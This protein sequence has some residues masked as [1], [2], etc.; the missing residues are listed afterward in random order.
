[1]SVK[2]SDNAKKFV[3]SGFMGLV[4]IGQA[5]ITFTPLF[6]NP[7]GGWY[8][9]LVDY[10]MYAFAKRE[11][12]HV[13]VRWIIEVETADGARREV[14]AEDMGLGF[15]RFMR[16]GMILVNNPNPNVVAHVTNAVGKDKK[17]VAIDV[18]K[19]PI[20]VTREGPKRVKPK[21]MRRVD[22]P[23]ISTGRKD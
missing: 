9:P 13:N 17:L 16:T 5:W 20:V 18:F 12:D 6:G 10:P 23:L 3:F 15:W 8:W 11:G 21:F 14:T 1:M 2:P 7:I 19:Y 22:L 4:L